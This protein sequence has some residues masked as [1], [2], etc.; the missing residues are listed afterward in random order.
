MN[1]KYIFPK[2][3]DNIDQTTYYWFKNGF[4]DEEITKIKEYLKNIEFQKGTIF[5]NTNGGFNKSVRDSEIKWIKC[6]DETKWIY[7]KIYNYAKE[8]NDSIFEFDLHFSLD[9]IQYSKY[10]LNGKYDWHIDIGSGKNSMRKLSCSVLLND[11]DEFKGGEFEFQTGKFPRNVPLK[12]G[13]VLFFPSFFL[14]RV[15][16][17]TS[18]ERESLV[19]WIGGD[20]YK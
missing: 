16:E 17:I 9:D 14:H 18:G 19:L 8:A 11:P 20:S 3:K 5:D 13:S 7:E 12:K 6:N 10:S 15:K 4:N 2:N 1:Q